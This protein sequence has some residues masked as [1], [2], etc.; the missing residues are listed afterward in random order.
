[1]K[2][3]NL[4]EQESILKEE[5]NKLI[6]GLEITHKINEM[7]E[8]RTKL[9]QE[10]RDHAVEQYNQTGEKKFGQIGIRVTT[11]YD[12]DEEE[13]LT[14]AMEHSLCL[15]LDKSS[16]KKQMKVQPL[17]FVTTEEV[18]T[19]TIPTEIKEVNNE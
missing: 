18:P 12:Y 9:E 1:M 5:K 16:F 19:A 7:S 15:S 13:A 10:I 3:K 14:W 4:R 2:L 6:E 17:D 8:K 11:K